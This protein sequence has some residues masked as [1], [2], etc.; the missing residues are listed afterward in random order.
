MVMIENILMS[1]DDMLNEIETMNMTSI[2]NIIFVHTI[3]NKL[4]A[5]YLS[6]PMK[7]IEK[8]RA[9]SAEIKAISE[10]RNKIFIDVFK[11]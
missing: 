8:I 3:K 4:L 7:N 10:E 1:P 6:E 11:Q 5:T 9:L 2:N